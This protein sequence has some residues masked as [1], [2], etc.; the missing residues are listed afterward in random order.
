MYY[1]NVGQSTKSITSGSRPHQFIPVHVD[2]QTIQEIDTLHFFRASNALVSLSLLRLFFPFFVC[3]SF[4]LFSFFSTFFVQLLFH[5]RSVW[6]FL[7]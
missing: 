5:L 6:L 7:E 3:F 2:R 1:L 4:L